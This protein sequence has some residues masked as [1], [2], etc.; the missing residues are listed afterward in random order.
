[1]PRLPRIAQRIALISAVLLVTALVAVL[2][3]LDPSAHKSRIEEAASRTLGMEVT[4]NGPMALRWRP[5]AYL[6]L[7]DVRARKAGADILAAKEAVVGLSLASLLGGRPQVRSVAMHDGTLAIVRDA[8]GRFNFQK[9]PVPGQARPARDLPDVSF[10]QATITYSRS[11]L[12]TAHRSPRLPRRD[13]RSC[14][15]P[16][17][18]VACWP[19]CRSMAKPRAPTCAAARWRSPTC[20]RRHAGERR[21]VRLPPDPHALV[22][23]AGQRPRARRLHRRGDGL[24]DRV[25]VAAV[26]RRAAAEGACR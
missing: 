1:M 23:C 21:R 6:V 16:V 24:S 8:N 10:S 25:H 4:V 12:R 26:S 11:S 17:A 15:P 18:S 20:A 22:R 9:D 14:T 3:L 7:R 2:A 13:R 5:T 19:A